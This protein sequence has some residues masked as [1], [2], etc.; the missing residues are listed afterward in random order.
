MA[1]PTITHQICL[2]DANFMIVVR[3][4]IDVQHMTGG[5]VVKLVKPDEEVFFPYWRITQIKTL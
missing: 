4:C 1:S 5:V 2:A 3:N